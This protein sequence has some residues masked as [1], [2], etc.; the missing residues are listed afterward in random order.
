TRPRYSSRY[1]PPVYNPGQRFQ[2]RG[3]WSNQPGYYYRR[4][5]YGDRLPWGWF[6]AQWWIDDYWFYDL[7]VP[8]FGYEWVRVGPD[9]LLVDIY[10]GEVVEVVPDLFF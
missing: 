5:A 2:W 8:P 7:P 3:G 1:F 4:W 10:T 9:A 6:R